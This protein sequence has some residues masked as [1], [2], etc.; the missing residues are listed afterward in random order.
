MKTGIEAYEE[1]MRMAGEQRYGD[2]YDAGWR[3]G[4][5]EAM[6]ISKLESAYLRQQLDLLIENAAKAASLSPPPVY[7]IKEP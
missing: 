2:G 4:Y 6:R 1:C 5:E 3:Q 7:L